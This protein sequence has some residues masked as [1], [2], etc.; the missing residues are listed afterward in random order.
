ML[1]EG[2]VAE[3]RIPF[4][5]L[6]QGGYV[7]YINLNT[8][9]NAEGLWP[10]E[11]TCRFGYPGFAMLCFL[12][13]AAGVAKRAGFHGV[14]IHGAHGYLI[15]QFLS[16]LSNKRT[17]AYGGDLAGRMRFALEIVDARERSTLPFL[18]DPQTHM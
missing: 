18:F 2:W 14:Q 15:H 16:P 13:A 4:S 12:A 9:V 1:P 17:D 3:F 8:I 10:L 5:Q 6:R 11:F 7:G